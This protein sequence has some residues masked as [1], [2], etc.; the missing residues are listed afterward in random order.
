MNSNTAASNPVWTIVPPVT[1]SY[2]LCLAP[3]RTAFHDLLIRL[4]M[5]L[6]ILTCKTTLGR[7]AGVISLAA[8]IPYIR[9]TLRGE[10]RP[11]RATWWIWT[12]VGVLLAAS[13]YSLGAR[14]T[15]W[16]PVS[17]VAG[18]LVTAILSIQHGEGGW[19]RLDR[20]SIAGAGISLLLW[21][22]TS[23]PLSTLLLNLL[24]DL[25]GAFPTLQKAYLRPEGE[26][27]AAWSLFF[28]GNSFNLFAIDN[29]KWTVLTYPFYMLA[30]SA[31][32][33]LFLL[34]PRRHHAKDRLSASR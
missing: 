31:T 4:F 27:R 2:T 10:T 1:L 6:N 13:Y 8:F 15:I 3:R 11:N 21:I 20:L 7:L 5:F 33:L 23:S 12:I 24:I 18:P 17:F 9:T 26:D 32:I 34:L 25:C 19:S 14:H 28:V 16:V 22:L 29:W 30:L